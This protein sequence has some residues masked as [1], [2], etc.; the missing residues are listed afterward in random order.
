[1]SDLARYLGDLLLFASALGVLMY[2]VSRRN[3]VRSLYP[4]SGQILLIVGTIIF[5]AAYLANVLGSDNLA[6]AFGVQV[7]GN[8]AVGISTEMFWLLTRSAAIIVLAGLV[9]GTRHRRRLE[10]DV[11]VTRGRVKDASEI[12]IQSESRFRHLFETTSNSIYCYTFDPPLP[13]NLPVEEQ[14]RRSHEAVLTE[15]NRVFA[16]ALDRQSPDQVIGS[17][18][19]ELDGNK[20][21]VAHADFF[22]S[23]IRNDY[24]L[25]DYELIY[26][27]PQGEDRAVRSSLTGIVSDGLL[28]RFWGAE[29]N[30]LDLRQTQAALRR[31]RH[32][33]EL[34]AEISSALVLANTKDADDAVT[35]CVS[36][37][38]KYIR[39]DRMTIFWLNGSH[40]HVRAAYSWGTTAERQNE[41]VTMADFPYIASQILDNND[42]HI[43]DLDSLPERFKA[44]KQGLQRTN[45]KSFAAIPLAVGGEVVGL[46]SLA[47]RSSKR[48]WT[49]QDISELRVFSD[50]FANYI[51]RLKAQRALDEALAGLKR[52][53]ARL[54]AENVYLRQ[55]I[56]L[57][58]GFDEIIGQSD[59]VRRCLQLV[60][61][62][63]DTMTPVLVLGETG[64]GKELIARAIHEHS[65]RRHRPL[66]KVNCAALPANL[67]ESELFGYEKGAFTGADRQK[68]GRFDLANGS[69]LFLDEIADI[70]L[71]LQAKLLRVLQEGEIERLGGNKTIKVNVRIIAATNRNLEEAV[72]NGEFRSDLFYRINTFPIELPPL[73]SR[74]DDIQLLAE[75]FVKIHSQN[76]GRE[77]TAISA[78]MMRR[79]HEYHWPG[80]VRELEGVIQRALISSSGP[81]LEL[82]APISHGKAEFDEDTPRV[83]SSSIPELQLVEREHI[84]ATLEKSDWKIAGQSGAAAKLGI[85]PSTLRSKMKKLSIVRPY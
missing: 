75:H 24:R 83:L 16:N 43:D 57:T 58:H 81:V 33:D 49:D 70:P 54:E 63:S 23:F 10:R 74:G 47:H 66:V 69:T 67:I 30:I 9:V 56:E 77:I 2:A 52:A 40:R 11:S 44:D 48:V 42:I 82:P 61:Q 39:A 76:L 14:I 71:E 3:V 46:S 28:H 6:A 13:I 80:N 84:L 68:R 50:L 7:P 18:M 27:T 62:V 29:S 5:A 55:E 31:R 21:A 60:E 36:K 79:M 4:R 65:S 59:G 34:L 32:F 78:E 26:T 37:V 15:C 8:L 72:K 35:D 25:T 22:G 1:M 20:D 41:T 73:R 51:H 19:G 64:T 12:V 45:V 53:T 38:C 85:P 17:K